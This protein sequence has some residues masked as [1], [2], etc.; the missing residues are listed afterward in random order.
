MQPRSPAAVGLT[1]V[2]YV[3]TTFAVQGTSHFMINARHYAEIP[4]MRAEPVIFMGIISMVVQGLIF[5]YLYPAFTRGASSIRQGVTFSLTMGA[6]LASYIILAEAGKYAIP[7]ILSWI[8]VEA[9]T[10]LVQ[11]ALFGVWLGL[12]HRS[13]P[14]L[15][16]LPA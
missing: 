14:A 2:A 8:A 16:T 9:S 7:S 11:F 13:S 1:V 3:A 10:A 15:A 12:I 6:F 5:A 4:I